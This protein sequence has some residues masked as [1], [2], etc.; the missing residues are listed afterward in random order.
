MVTLHVTGGHPARGLEIRSIKVSNSMYLARNI[1]V[2]N[3]QMCFLTM[4][5]KARKRRGNTDYIIQFLPNKVS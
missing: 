1:Y 3:G 2:I 5:D 4:Y